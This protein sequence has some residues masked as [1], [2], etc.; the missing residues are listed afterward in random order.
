MKNFILNVSMNKATRSPGI[1]E[2]NCTAITLPSVGIV[3]DRSS[4]R[5]SVTTPTRGKIL[6]ASSGVR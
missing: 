3:T 5:W 2:K 4:S 1:E 6:D